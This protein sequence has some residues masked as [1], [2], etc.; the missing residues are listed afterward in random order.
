MLNR[1]RQRL[2]IYG[3]GFD[4]ASVLGLLLPVAI[5]LLIGIIGWALVLTR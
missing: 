3:T 5:V 1:I 2:G 4:P